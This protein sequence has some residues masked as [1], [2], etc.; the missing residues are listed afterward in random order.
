MTSNKVQ[1]QPVGGYHGVTVELPTVQMN[2]DYE[3]GKIEL[4]RGYL[5]FVTHP[6]VQAIEQT[7]ARL[8]QT[9]LALSFNS[10]ASA[11]F[12]LMD[13]FFNVRTKNMFVDGAVAVDMLN[14]LKESGGEFIKSSS[15]ETADVVFVELASDSVLPAKKKNQ[16][17]FGIDFNASTTP[18]AFRQQ[19]DALVV[20]YPD[21]KNGFIIFYN[22][23]LGTEIKLLRRHTGY[24]LSSRQA[25]RLVQGKAQAEPA[26]LRPLKQKLAR[27]E[28]GDPDKVWLFP[29]GMGAISTAILANL[30]AERPGLVMI[31]SPY[32]DTRCILENWPGCRGTPPA[33]FLEV[34][35]L[36]GIEAAI[37][38]QTALVICEI[39][40]NPL[41]RVPDLGKIV[42]FA[43][44]RG[45]KVLVDNT[46]ASPYNLNPFE[47]AVDIIAH[48]T[49]KSLNG[50]NDHLGGAL[51]VKASVLA[52]KIARYYRRLN[53]SMDPTDVAVLNHHLDSFEERM[54]AMNHNALQLARF[55]EAH[56]KI[57]RVYYPGLSS[58]PDFAVAQ[59]YFKGFGSLIS[60]T[61]KGEPEKATRQFYDNVSAPVQKAPS[62]GS[63]Q[64]L[65]CLYVILAH[66]NDPPAKLAQMGLEKYLLR[67][68]VG[69]EPLATIID[70][71]EKAL[72]LVEDVS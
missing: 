17:V 14:F 34:N 11:L 9:E 29:S 40:T 48:S 68:S 1:A 7:V 8:Y 70:V 44:R 46:I 50:F 3:E 6:D 26:P 30:S 12:V 43:H 67:I 42:T 51:L 57:K 38:D 56:P 5:R 72:E 32:V 13:A 39:P 33:A 61:L 21:D 66:Y 53:L 47:Y 18:G 24:N 19:C 62:L 16:F 60:F 25:E 28:K 2:I 58:H 36:P 52:E 59:Q 27:L 45:A 23:E 20:G 37:N 31:G 69:I 54:E 41:L 63:A 10:P 71:F 4:N 55:L 64:S 65:L 35:D 22:Q 49:T 15:I